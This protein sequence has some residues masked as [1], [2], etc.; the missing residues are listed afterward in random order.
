MTLG[1]PW[2]SLNASVVATNGARDPVRAVAGTP[3]LLSPAI[4]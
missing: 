3:L 2:S 1:S 4:P